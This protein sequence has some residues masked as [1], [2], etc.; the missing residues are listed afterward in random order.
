MKIEAIHR[1]LTNRYQKEIV[2]KQLIDSWLEALK[3]NAILISDFRDA[4]N[5]VIMSVTN[6]WKNGV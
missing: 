6:N 3:D 1:R 5:Y 4:A 2:F